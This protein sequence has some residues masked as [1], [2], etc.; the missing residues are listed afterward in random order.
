MDVVHLGMYYLRSSSQP[1]TARKVKILI[2]VRTRHTH[3]YSHTA[4]SYLFKG[5]LLGVVYLCIIHERLVYDV[6][7]VIIAVWN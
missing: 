5:D 1:Q 4:P 7:V 6:V 2:T 3:T